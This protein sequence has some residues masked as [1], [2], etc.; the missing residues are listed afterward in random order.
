MAAATGG[1]RAEGHSEEKCE[2]GVRVEGDTD[3]PGPQ[4]SQHRA[5]H[6]SPITLFPG[7]PPP[8][9]MIR[10][11]VRVI[12]GGLMCSL[13][14][15]FASRSKYYPDFA[16]DIGGELFKRISQRGHFSQRDAFAMLRY[17]PS[18]SSP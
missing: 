18:F 1:R 15:W 8:C 16:F 5:C 11:H 13:F 17:V 6:F 9:L 2:G 7:L 12:V 4:P 14:Q 3:P 10:V